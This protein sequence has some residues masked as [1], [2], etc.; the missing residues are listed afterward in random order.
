MVNFHSPHRPRIEPE[1]AARTAQLE[2]HLADLFREFAGFH[3]FGDLARVHRLEF[4]LLYGRGGPAR[5]TTEKGA[6]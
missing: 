2:R 5:L 1:R 4:D 6:A 3:A